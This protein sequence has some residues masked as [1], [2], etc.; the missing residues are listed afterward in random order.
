MVIL[1][2]FSKNLLKK[3]NKEILINFKEYKEL[4]NDAKIALINESIKSLK[5][6]IMI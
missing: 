4:N 5:K 1:K 2:K 6:I 3:N